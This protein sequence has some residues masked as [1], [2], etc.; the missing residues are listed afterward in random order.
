MTTRRDVLE[1]MGVALAATGATIMIADGSTF[2]EPEFLI[3]P[4]RQAS[5]GDAKVKPSDILYARMVS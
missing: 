3:N 5:T 2:V 1:K 4:W